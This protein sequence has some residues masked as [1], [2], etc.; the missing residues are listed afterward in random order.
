MKAHLKSIAVPKTWKIKKKQSKYIL[1]PNPGKK[2]MYS[3]ALGLVLKLLG[4]AKTAKEVSLI[5]NTKNVIVDGTRR[6]DQ[7]YPVGLMDVVSISELKEDYQMILDVRGKLQMVPFKNTSEK[8]CKIT[9]KK[10]HKG[11]FQLSTFDSRTI[12]VDNGKDYKTG[13]SVIVSVPDQK[14][15]GHLKLQKGAYVF[16]IGGKNIGTKGVVEDLKDEKISV[17]S[18][19]EKVETLK[20]HAYVVKA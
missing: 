19:N 4:H 13:D 18:E 11:K 15:K 14:V 17:K 10:L 16:L 6:K 1:R 9:G 8:V 2:M 20:Q 12:I 5:L 7:K 3:M